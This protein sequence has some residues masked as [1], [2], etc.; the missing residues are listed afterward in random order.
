MSELHKEMGQTEWQNMTVTQSIN[1]NKTNVCIYFIIS[2]ILVVYGRAWRSMAGR[3]PKWASASSVVTL[4]R[5]FSS[6][7]RN[8]STPWD[9]QPFRQLVPVVHYIHS[10]FT[11]LGSETTLFSFLKQPHIPADHYQLSYSPF[12]LGLKSLQFFWFVITDTLAKFLIIPTAFIWRL[13]GPNPSWKLFWKPAAWALA[14]VSRTK[15]FVCVL[16]VL[17]GLS[18]PE[19]YFPFFSTMGSS[20]SLVV[21]R[22]SL[23]TCSVEVN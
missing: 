4:E 1:T 19:W 14:L 22:Y 12:L 15:E 23:G 3:Q 21:P 17:G 5:C 6:F 20:G 18:T 10:L 13:F 16:V 2:C 11:T 7:F 8:V 9:L